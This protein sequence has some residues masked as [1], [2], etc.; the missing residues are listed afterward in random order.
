[1]EEKLRKYGK[2]KLGARSRMERPPRDVGAATVSS[3][4][5]LEAGFTSWST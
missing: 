2:M 4:A 3:A 1:L 5:T